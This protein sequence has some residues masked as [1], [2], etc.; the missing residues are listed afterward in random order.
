VRVLSTWQSLCGSTLSPT[1]SRERER[2]RTA[3]A[4]AFN[5]I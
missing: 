2:G 3:V 1:L 5:L 4:A